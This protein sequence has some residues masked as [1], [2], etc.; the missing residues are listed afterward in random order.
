MCL[1]KPMK[2]IEIHPDLHTGTVDA[3]GAKMQVG[4]DLAPEAKIGDFVLIHA[5]VA[6]EILAEKD[7][8]DIIDAYDE[9]VHNED[10]FSP[11][12]AKRNES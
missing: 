7:A 1:A 9:F 2:I 4:L 6:I 3:G 10:V 11:D 5:G 8:Q 12:D